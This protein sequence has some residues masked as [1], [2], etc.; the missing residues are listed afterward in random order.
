V[1]ADNLFEGALAA[2]LNPLIVPEELAEVIPNNWRARSAARRRST[3]TVRSE[4]RQSA[5]A[6]GHTLAGVKRMTPEE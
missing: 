3:T 4:T 5:R 1:Y 2:T 6:V